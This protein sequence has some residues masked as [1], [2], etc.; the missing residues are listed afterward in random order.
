MSFSIIV[1]Q[2]WGML[3]FCQFDLEQLSVL[4][5]GW[6]CCCYWPSTPPSFP[7][8]GPL[9]ANNRDW[10]LS[11]FRC[12][13]IIILIAI[14]TY[15]LLVVYDDDIS[16]LPFCCSLQINQTIFTFLT[17][18]KAVLNSSLQHTYPFACAVPKFSMLVS[19]LFL[20][21]SRQ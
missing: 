17:G 16:S 12:G 9:L 2:D 8:H 4:V 6:G 19:R 7:Q 20:F 13:D 18:W 21:K 15:L 11:V 10:T 1:Q 14:P 5:R 3:F